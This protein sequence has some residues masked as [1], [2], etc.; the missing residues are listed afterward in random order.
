MP[1]IPSFNDFAT[2]SLS[3]PRQ[4]TIPNPV[5]TTRFIGGPL[6]Q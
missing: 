5:I 1:E 6:I 2:V 3:F 4:E